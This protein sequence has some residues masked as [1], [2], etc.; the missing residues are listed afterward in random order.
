MNLNDEVWDPTEEDVLN[1]KILMSLGKSYNDYYLY[2]YGRDLAEMLMH[3]DMT[4]K[5][6]QNKLPLIMQDKKNYLAIKERMKA[7]LNLLKNPQFKPG[8]LAALYRFNV[9]CVVVSEPYVKETTGKIVC[10]ALYDGSVGEVEINLLRSSRG[11]KI[12][13]LDLSQIQ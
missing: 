8:D 6:M 5:K 3:L 9:L 12:Q 4:V 10:Q 7:K 11:K 13:S 2:K 1:I